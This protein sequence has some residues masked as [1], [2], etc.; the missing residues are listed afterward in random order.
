MDRR[1][2]YSPK[3]RFVPT[4]QRFDERYYR[5]RYPSPPH[6]RNMRG[7]YDSRPVTHYSTSREYNYHRHSSPSSVR[8]NTRITT[9]AAIEELPVKRKEEEEKKVTKEEEGKEKEGPRP[10]VIKE[11][12]ISFDSDGEDDWANERREQSPVHEE[13]KKESSSVIKESKKEIKSENG[14]Q[15]PEPWVS[16]KTEQGQVYY[17]N[18]LTRKSVWDRKEI[19]TDHSSSNSSYRPVGRVENYHRSEVRQTRPRYHSSSRYPSPPP[20]TVSPSPPNRYYPSRYYPSSPLSSPPIQPRWAAD[21]RM[22]R[23]NDPYDRRYR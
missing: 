21:R 6:I 8:Q 23:R 13:T 5:P 4:R 1:Y 16:H 7:R 3:S 22:I 2:G 17:Y 15:L 18:Q 9:E 12:V 14:E 10:A 20:R 11:A 19:V